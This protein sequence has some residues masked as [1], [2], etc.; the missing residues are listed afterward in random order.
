LFFDKSVRSTN[1]KW[2]KE[3]KLRKEKK[4]SDK[5]VNLKKK[6]VE[7]SEKVKK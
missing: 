3:E 1:K 5:I 6:V 7:K 2:I 4:H